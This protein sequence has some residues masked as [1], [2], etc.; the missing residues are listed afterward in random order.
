[1]SLILVA[2]CPLTLSASTWHR[3]TST[4]DTFTCDRANESAIRTFIVVIIII[5]I[6]I[7]LV[8]LA[9]RQCQHLRES[10][11]G[12]FCMHAAKIRPAQSAAGCVENSLTVR[13]EWRTHKDTAFVRQ[14]N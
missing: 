6:I 3:Q 2:H 7:I 8:V 10:C 4:L 9:S 1:M 13:R 12:L 5:I 14:G 11:V